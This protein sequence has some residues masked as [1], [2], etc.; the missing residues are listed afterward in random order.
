MLPFVDCERYGIEEISAVPGDG[1]ILKLK[2]GCLNTGDNISHLGG[3]TDRCMGVCRPERWLF[4]VV[5]SG[6]EQIGRDAA[7]LLGQ[8][9][10]NRPGPL[11]RARGCML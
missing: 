9:W 7:G 4:P 3:S 6:C 11:G 5:I 1:D 2:Q 8:E 10:R